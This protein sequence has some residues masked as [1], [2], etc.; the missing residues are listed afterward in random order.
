MSD[1]QEVER[2]LQEGRLDM[3]DGEPKEE[4]AI[5]FREEFRVMGLIE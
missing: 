2:L 3:I 1:E 4:D 5:D